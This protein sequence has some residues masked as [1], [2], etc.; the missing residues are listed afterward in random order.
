MFLRN[1]F[2]IVITKNFASN[3]FNGDVLEMTNCLKDCYNL[4]KWMTIQRTM[5]DISFEKE[6]TEKSFVDAD[7]LAGASCAG[8]ACEINW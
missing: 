4:H 3:Y 8:G 7:T 6:L 1:N 2:H 5:K